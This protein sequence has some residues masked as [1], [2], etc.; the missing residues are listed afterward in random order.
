M[1][2]HMPNPE[3]KVRFLVEQGVDP[4]GCVAVGDGYTDIPL[5]D[6]ANTAVMLDRAGR[7]RIKYGHKNYRFVKS[8]TEVTDCLRTSVK[9]EKS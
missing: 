3:D 8:L 2:L 9:N 4:A 6:W 5:L 7:K 1:T